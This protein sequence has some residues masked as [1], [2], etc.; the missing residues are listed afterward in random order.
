MCAGAGTVCDYANYKEC[1]SLYKWGSGACE[2]EAKRGARG[3]CVLGAELSWTLVPRS[4]LRPDSFYYLP[5]LP[6]WGALLCFVETCCEITLPRWLLVSD[7][8][9]ISGSPNPRRLTTETLPDLVTTHLLPTLAP[10]RA[11]AHPMQPGAGGFLVG[12]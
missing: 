6:W 3:F 2:R 12:F 5:G 11:L 10:K 8:S 7:I 1:P 9:E 4:I